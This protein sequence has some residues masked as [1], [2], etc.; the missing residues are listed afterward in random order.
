[1]GTSYYGVDK[2]D[3]RETIKL[4]KESKKSNN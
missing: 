4:I 2:S 3:I 1:M